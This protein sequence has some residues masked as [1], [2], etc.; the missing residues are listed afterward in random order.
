MKIPAWLC[1]EYKYNRSKKEKQK[2]VSVPGD[3]NMKLRLRSWS[4]PAVIWVLVQENVD[5]KVTEPCSVLHTGGD[6]I[7][8]LLKRNQGGHRS[9]P[10][11]A[12]A[13]RSRLKLYRNNPPPLHTPAPAVPDWIWLRLPVA[14]HF[15]TLMR[16]QM[17][18]KIQRLKKYFFLLISCSLQ[19]FY[20][21]FL[22]RKKKRKKKT[23]RFFGGIH[24]CAAID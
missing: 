23:K 7:M 24:N 17:F 18:E 6:T 16:F 19:R 8:M 3:A 10:S 5:K 12:S 1:V 9:T 21:V 2:L 22:R 11:P 20:F 4:A 14:T 13:S 15:P